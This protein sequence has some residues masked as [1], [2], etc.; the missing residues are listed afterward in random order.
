MAQK[1]QAKQK[2]WLA[3]VLIYIFVPL[4]IWFLAFVAW[5]YWDS[6]SGFFPKEKAPALERSTPR[7]SSAKR[8][9][10][11]APRAPPQEKILDDDRK[12]LEDILKRR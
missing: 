6:L 4:T 3:T 2:N 1:K 10:E 7:A 11:N 8:Q 12:Q 9:A 5:L